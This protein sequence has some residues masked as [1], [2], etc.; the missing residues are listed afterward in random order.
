MNEALEIAKS[1]LIIIVSLVAFLLILNFSADIVKN[2]K[3][4]NNIKKLKKRMDTVAAE[5]TVLKTSIAKKGKEGRTKL[6]L[7]EYAA[8]KKAYS[9]KIFLTDP[10]FNKINNG[11]KVYIYYEKHNP[12]NC[13]LKENWEELAYKYYIQWDIAY[14]L[15]ILIF[16]AINCIM[17][18]V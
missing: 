3:K 16:V 18:L 5:A 2:I 10:V 8:D 1:V 14:I 4:I 7:F 11:D 9:R 6:V 12:E 17:K 13:V 15:C